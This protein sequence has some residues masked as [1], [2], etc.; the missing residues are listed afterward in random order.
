MSKNTY[1]EQLQTIKTQIESLPGSYRFLYTEPKSISSPYI[2]VG[3]NPGG[4]VDDVS[5]LYV[6]DD[7]AYVHEKW[8]KTG[9][10]YNPLQ[11]QVIY[12]FQQMAD[13]LGHNEWIRFMS[14]NWLISNYVFYRSPRWPEMAAK[15]AHIANSKAIWKQLFA[16][17]S[18]KII[19]ANGYDTYENMILLLNEAGWSKLS[20]ERTER[21][22]DGPHISI[23]QKD[24]LRC[25]VIG[26]AHLSTF[27]I[28]KREENKAVMA[29]IYKLIKKYY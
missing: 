19:V 10:G 11:Q 25:L 22:W 21:A 12:F 5:D 4:K 17:N 7:N 28:I 6:E 14:E 15:K 2:F 18:P 13:H 20:E 26:F 23:L 8:N 3:L 1:S 29:G 16:E 27:K 24:G 9:K